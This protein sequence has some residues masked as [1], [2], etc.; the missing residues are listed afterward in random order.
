MRI[1]P[2]LLQILILSAGIHLFLR[3]VRHTR[4]SR[5]IRGLYVSVLLGWVGLWGLSKPLG[6]EELEHILQGATGFLVVVFA[7]VFQPELRRGIAQL[8]ERSFGGGLT[9]R[10]D[11]DVVRGVVRAARS[12]VARRHGALIAFEKETS[13]KTYVET[14]AELDAEV[15]ARLIESLFNPKGPLHDGAIVIQEGRISAAGCFFP[16]PQEGEFDPSMGTRHRAALGLTEDNDAVVL[17]VSEETGSISIAHEGEIRANVT[18]DRLEEE[19]HHLLSSTPAGDRA[20]RRR[21]LPMGGS[22]WRGDLFWLLASV[23]LAVGILAVAHQD[24]RTTHQFSVRVSGSSP[25]VTPAPGDGDLLVVLPEESYRLAYPGEF[26]AKIVVHGSRSQIDALG[27]SLSGIYPLEDVERMKAPLDL[28]RV[29]WK[30][31]IFGLEYGW[32]EP[33]PE[34]ELERYEWRAVTVRAEDIVID[35]S[36]LDPRYEVRHDGVRVAADS[37]LRIQG[38]RDVVE[39]LLQTIPLELEPVVLTPNDRAERLVRVGLAKAMLD[40]RLSTAPGESVAVTIPIVPARREAGIVTREVALVSMVPDRA[41]ELALWTLPA[42]AQNA[43]FSIRTSGLIPAN[44][45]PGSPAVVERFAAIRRFVE[46]NLLV[47]VDVAE[48][49]ENGREVPVRWTWRKDWREAQHA[50]GL[51]AGSLGTHDELDVELESEKVILLE[52]RGMSAGEDDSSG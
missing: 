29:Q 12:M 27:G 45:D 1:L 20:E 7:I 42:H 13:L 11:P 49:P 4:G 50:L 48:L 24:I 19:L 15:S 44:A 33:V 8:G 14:G 2:W 46:E 34:L 21:L 16:L 5:L 23:V 52:R 35:D 47:Y 40:L 25:T 51:D 31:P 37:T 39:Q 36:A 3:F 38:P 30:R 22:S 26:T 43:R 9:S 10:S 18:E 28:S 17:I 41:G 32:A 6:L